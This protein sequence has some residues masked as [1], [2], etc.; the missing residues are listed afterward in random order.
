MHDERNDRDDCAETS[1]RCRFHVVGNS[2]PK[3]RKHDDKETDTLRDSDIPIE[4]HDS[5]PSFMLVYSFTA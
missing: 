2:D 4:W 5:S 1:D 3:V